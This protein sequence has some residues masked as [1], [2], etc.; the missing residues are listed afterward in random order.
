[1][2]RKPRIVLVGSSG[3]GRGHVGTL[4]ELIGAIRRHLGLRGMVLAGVQLVSCPTGLDAATKADAATALVSRAE[5]DPVVSTVTT[6]ADANMIAADADAILAAAIAFGEVDGLICV[7][8]APSGAN[9][10]VAEAAAR[11]AFP[12]SGQAVPRWLP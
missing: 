9:R 4:D 2:E 8:S 12:L 7:S 6:L 11:A 10:R 5:N 1:M 3:G